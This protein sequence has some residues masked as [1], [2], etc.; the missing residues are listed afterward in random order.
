MDQTTDVSLENVSGIW[1]GKHSYQPVW[2][3]Q[4]DLH[5]HCTSGGRSPI[6]LFVEH[7]PVI[8]LGKH[9]NEENLLL[10]PM[11]YE[12]IGVDLI[13]IDR[14]GKATA[15]EPGQ[16]TIYPI[17]HLPSFNLKP[18][19][20]I[21]LLESCVID[22]LEN[23]GVSGDRNAKWPG[24]WVGEL[25][26]CA[27]GVRIKERT[28]MHGLGFNVSN[29]LSTFKYIVPCGIKDRQIISLSHILQRPV[30]LYEVASTFLNIFAKHLGLS[31]CWQ[32]GQT[33]LLKIKE[34]FIVTS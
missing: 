28:T 31:P 33:S 26:I 15:H 5:G 22:V 4:K 6:I 9:S 32:V 19:D 25:K 11:D 27:V 1:L 2:D 34:D 24:V 29:D 12:G 16:L 18:K 17:L 23:Y 13:R 7:R 3:L 20:Y 30:D 21:Y 14:G 10:E 8:T